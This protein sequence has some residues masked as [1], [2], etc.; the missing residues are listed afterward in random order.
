MSHHLLTSSYSE[1]AEKNNIK[2]ILFNRNY[3]E[4]IEH[5]NTLGHIPININNN[6]I[7]VH[8]YEKASYSY[9]NCHY[10]HTTVF[11]HQ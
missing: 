5:Y 2:Q 6:E 9:Q 7:V 1:L 11:V 8:Q 10:C 4:T 3:G